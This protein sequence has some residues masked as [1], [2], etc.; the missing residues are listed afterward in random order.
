[1][2]RSQSDAAEALQRT[3][4]Q[5]LEDQRMDAAR[6]LRVLAKAR[7]EIR[8]VPPAGAAGPMRSRRS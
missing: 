3:L 2:T 7:R 5:L 6:A 4:E 1:M 8:V